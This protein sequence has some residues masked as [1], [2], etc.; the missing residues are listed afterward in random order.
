MDFELTDEHSKT[1]RVEREP[2]VATDSFPDFPRMLGPHER[3]V[4]QIDYPTT[5]WVGFPHPH[6]GKPQTYTMQAVFEITPDEASKKSGV[7][8]GR[9]VSKAENY[10]FH[11]S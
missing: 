2:L 8:T 4:F 1:R 10:V 5:K 11:N 3:L 6:T 9:I 7:W